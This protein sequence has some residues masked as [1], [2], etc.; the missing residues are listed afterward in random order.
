MLAKE[1]SLTLVHSAKDLFSLAVFF[2]FV[3]SQYQLKMTSLLMVLRIATG[4]KSSSHLFSKLLVLVAEVTLNPQGCPREKKIPVCIFFVLF[5][6]WRK[7]LV[8][9]YWQE[10]KVIDY[11]LSCF[12]WLSSGYTVDFGSVDKQTNK[13]K[14]VHRV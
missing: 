3:C 1:L 6:V 12:P 10:K 13:K 11:V 2:S 14:K 4:L 9:V 8:T 5:F 7:P